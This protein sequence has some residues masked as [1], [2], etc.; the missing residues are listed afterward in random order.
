MSVLPAV[1]PSAFS[2]GVQE[3]VS[4]GADK[5]NGVLTQPPSPRSGRS[6][7]IFQ[8]QQKRFAVQRASAYPNPVFFLSCQK[9]K[10]FGCPKEKPAWQSFG[11]FFCIRRA[12]FELTLPRAPLP[13]MQQASVCQATARSPAA[14]VKERPASGKVD[15]SPVTR[16]RAAKRVR[17]VLQRTL[18]VWSVLKLRGVEP[19]PV[20]TGWIPPVLR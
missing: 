2:L 20:F 16:N 18:A 1:P 17:R 9:E 15:A 7:P 10:G 4:F 8:R 3:P 11:A 6:A 14:V 12:E 19:L 13:L 5:R